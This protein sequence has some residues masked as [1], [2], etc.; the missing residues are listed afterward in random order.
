MII[1]KIYQL[2]GIFSEEPVLTTDYQCFTF[3]V[4]LKKN[5]HMF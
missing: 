1:L 2:D 4:Q 3:I 5:L